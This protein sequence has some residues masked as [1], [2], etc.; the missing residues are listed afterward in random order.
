M[1]SWEAMTKIPVV[2]NLLGKKFLPHNVCD[3]SQSYNIL[4]NKTYRQLLEFGVMA[5][6]LARKNRLNG[7]V[8][9]PPQYSKLFK[10]NVH[11]VDR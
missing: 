2:K 5:D 11:P 3:D 9:D 7:E 10:C 6:K 8:Y 1:R 4:K